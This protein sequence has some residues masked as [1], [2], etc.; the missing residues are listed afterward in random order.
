VK[1]VYK[2]GWSKVKNSIKTPFTGNLGAKIRIQ[3][4]RLNNSLNRNNRGLMNS[5][6]HGR[7]NFVQAMVVVWSRFKLS[8]PMNKNKMA[9]ILRPIAKQ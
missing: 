6:T 2:K 9:R 5:I 7:G 3:V 8:K 1:T 4:N